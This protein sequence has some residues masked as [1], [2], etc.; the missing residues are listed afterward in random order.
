LYAPKVTVAASSGP[1]CHRVKPKTQI[2][3]SFP[4]NQIVEIPMK[5]NQTTSMIE[6]ATLPAAQS[7]LRVT[8][9]RFIAGRFGITGWA[10]LLLV[11]AGPVFAQ[12]T[13]VVN[14]VTTNAPSAATVNSIVLTSYTTNKGRLTIAVNETGSITTSIRVVLAGA[15]TLTGSTTN[16]LGGGNL[17]VTN[18]YDYSP[19]Y[20]SLSPTGVPGTGGGAAVVLGATTITNVANGN[21]NFD[22]LVSLNYTNLTSADYDMAVEASGAN[23]W[24]YPLPVKAGFK[25][26]AGGGANTNFNNT[27]NWIGGI[28]PGTGNIVILDDA[29]T[30]TSNGIPTVAI[31]ADTTIGSISDI[32]T[33]NYTHLNIAANATLLLSGDAGYRQLMDLI[34]GT[35]LSK[36]RASGAGTMIVSNSNAEFN[37]FTYNS[38]VTDNGDFSALNTLIVDVRKIAI[39]DIAA[40]PNYRTN[41]S[42]TLPAANIYDWDWALTNI[43]RATHTDANNWANNTRDYGL[44]INRERP[45]TGNDGAMHFGLYNE[46]YFDSILFGG[47]SQM[48]NPEIDFRA[49][50]GSYIKIRNTDKVSRV[51]NITLADA[52][53]YYATIGSSGATRG[54]VSFAKGTNDVLVDTLMI[55][56]DPL[57][58][59]NGPAT[60]RL[61]LGVGPFDVN[62]AFVGYQTGSG[63]GTENGYAAGEVHLNN[64]SIFRVNNTLVLGYSVVTSNTVVGGYGQVNI[65]S[66]GVAYLNTVTAGGPAGAT[67]N[68]TSQRISVNTGG[69]LILSNS[70]CS[71]SARL[72][73]F[74]MNNAKLTLPSLS[75]N[76]TSIPNIYCTTLTST[77]TSNL[78]EILNLTSNSTPSYPVRIPVISYTGSA[79]PNFSVSVP[80]GYFAFPINN[81][82]S[83]TVDVVVSVVPPKALVWDGDASGSWDTSSGN[84]KSGLLFTDGDGVT[85]DDTAAGP[86]FAV[87][88]AEVV[89]GNGG[90]L[91]TNNSQAYS[92]AGG[93]I[94]GTSTMTKQGANN[95]TVTATSVLPIA[96]NQGSLTV[97]S[98]G[99]VGI[100][101]A[102]VGTT[103]DVN[104][105]G[106]VLRLN[107]AGTAANAGTLNGMSVSGGVLNNTGTINGSYAISG[108]SGSSIVTN[109]TGS[110]VNT[111]GVSTMGTNST[112]V[113]NGEMNLG[114]A[115]VNSRFSMGG[116]L[117][118]SGTIFDT[119]GDTAGNNGRVEINPGGVFT[120]GG[121]NTIGTFTIGARFD[122]N[123]GTP[124]G[125]L[126]IDIDTAHANTNDVLGV[127][128][129]SNFRG[130]LT[131][132]N[133][134]ASPFAVGQT[135]RIF[136][137][138]FIPPGGTNASEA[139]FDLTNKITPVVPGVGLKWDVSNLKH[140]GLI[141]VVQGP[142]TQPTLTSSNAGG[143]NMIFSWPLSHVGYQLQVQTNNL[144]VGLNTNWYGLS[145]TEFVATTNI[146]INPTNPSVFFR[147]SNK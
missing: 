133:I 86:N 32:H 95:L 45:Q 90:V 122:L 115:N 6:S 34:G 59:A 1:V 140:F 22:V 99:N 42:T 142:L 80:S 38:A 135:F 10:A 96:L 43:L 75:L 128:K 18:T 76:N 119:T 8:T 47:N 4:E 106:T 14:I 107:S 94:Y 79:A 16:D 41:G 109:H 137:N 63:V 48:D 77:G 9:R 129:W 132:N 143:T 92:L 124:D 49:A 102:A 25:W 53:D 33:S 5:T 83:N 97:A 138:N 40:Y 113:H 2:V 31:T 126:I 104:S 7:T 134:G 81:T 71:P 78:I 54:D 36:I 145:G 13:N 72:N 67:L 73:T 20:A 64:G 93:P 130:A 131:M 27:A 136:V 62:N 70:V 105:G 46:L 44:T 21:S 127:D 15:Q 110:T 17:D 121:A 103:V 101:T 26:S 89:V 144:D 65:N 123:T 24:R 85:F 116:T 147:L 118:G 120:P 69:Q 68:N 11:A 3:E 35:T 114:N 82:A 146:P 98:G 37:L 91:F 87:T 108:T 30:V 88:A 57:T 56:R 29:G 84:W 100:T 141:S 125:R 55:A 51:S 39:N 139:A 74:L 58:T 112:L 61:Y 50:S 23:T 117:T 52:M 60:G 66:G 12:T 28:V 111:V 19:K